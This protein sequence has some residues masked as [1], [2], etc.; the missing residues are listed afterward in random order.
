L[1]CREDERPRRHSPKRIIKAGY[2]VGAGAELKPNKNWFLRAEYRY[3]AFKIDGD[4]S[5]ASSLT[6]TSVL[7]TA[8]PRPSKAPLPPSAWLSSALFDR[9]MADAL[10]LSKEQ[11]VDRAS[12]MLEL[13]VEG[14]GWPNRI[15]GLPVPRSPLA[16]AEDVFA[17]AG[18]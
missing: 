17:E 11:P 13:A 5:T 10:T 6:S 12:V 15:T 1:T 9:W 14:K 8:T 2:T 4:G 18:P 3:L 16:A 7:G